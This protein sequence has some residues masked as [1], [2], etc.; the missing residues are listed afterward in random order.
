MCGPR[1]NY[2]KESTVVAQNNVTIEPPPHF[3]VSALTLAIITIVLLALAAYYLLQR[4]R[5]SIVRDVVRA[6]STLQLQPQ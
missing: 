6:Q 4:Y 5:R 1:T 3:E 2:K